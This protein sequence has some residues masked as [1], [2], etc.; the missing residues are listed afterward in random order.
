MKRN[1]IVDGNNFGFAGMASAKLS[2]GETETQAV[3][4][5]LK[6]IHSIHEEYPKA[7]VTVLWDGRS[8]RKDIY[9]EYKANREKTEEQATA[10]ADYKKQSA[11]IK[12]SRRSTS[13]SFEYGS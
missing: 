8:W 9:P 5:F 4:S 3:F 1:V 12:I 7:L 6:R 2:S 11:L 10:R 13:Y